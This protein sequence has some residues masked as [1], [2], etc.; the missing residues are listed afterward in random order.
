MWR[1]QCVSARAKRGMMPSDEMA[2][3][4]GIAR[5]GSVFAAGLIEAAWNMPMKGM[6]GEY[7]GRR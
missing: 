1:K 5:A 3:Q 7:D 6:T 2:E 4:T